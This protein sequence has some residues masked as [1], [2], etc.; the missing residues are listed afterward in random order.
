VPHGLHLVE[1]LAERLAHVVERRGRRLVVGRLPP[2]MRARR[3]L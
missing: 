2:A 3:V 1:L